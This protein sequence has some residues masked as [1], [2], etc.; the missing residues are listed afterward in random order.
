LRLLF[1][2][3]EFWVQFIP[4]TMGLIWCAWFLFRNQRDWNWRQHGPALLIV[5]LLTTP[6]AWLSDEV[7]LLPA[8][9][10]AAA[11][12]YQVRTDMKV[13]TRLILVIFALLNAVLLLI[14][15]SKIPFA[16]GIYFW[17]SMLWFTWYFFASSR[18][19]DRRVN[20]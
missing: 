3:R 15:K 18:H 20:K 13:T 7:V 8:I 10:E 12:M 5:S 6:Y 1:F 19:S 9:L 4:M 11:F 14:L 17:S 16:T 2:R